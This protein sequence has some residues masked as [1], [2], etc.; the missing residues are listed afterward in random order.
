MPKSL[1]ITFI[2]LTIIAVIVA[3]TFLIHS[4]INAFKKVDIVLE[5]DTQYFYYS[6][7][8]AYIRIFN[9]TAFIRDDTNARHYKFK[10]VD[11]NLIELTPTDTVDVTALKGVYI[12][13]DTIYINQ[14]RRY[15]YKEQ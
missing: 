9:N 13:P 5:D 10:L 7:D 3:A 4:G 8:G 12:N 14:L 6:E 2:I 15:F 1:K 11:G